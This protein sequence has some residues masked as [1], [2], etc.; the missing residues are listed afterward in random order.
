MFFG[1]GSALSSIFMGRV[2][3][4][5]SSKKSVVVNIFIM[6][7]TAFVSIKNVEDG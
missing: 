1:I 6:I 7:L 4:Y 5:T 2:I 3:D